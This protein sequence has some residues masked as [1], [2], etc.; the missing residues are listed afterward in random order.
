MNAT[1]ITIN[2]IYNYQAGNYT[3]VIEGTNVD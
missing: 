3:A 1:A 2:A